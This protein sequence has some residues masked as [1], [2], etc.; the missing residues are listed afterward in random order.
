MKLDV[1]RYSDNGE[2]TLGLLFI[3]GKFSVYTLED[4]YRNKKIKHETRI[5]S[6]TYTVKLRTIGGHHER[7]KH[8]FNF[9]KGMLWL[10]DVENFEWILIHI[11]NDRKSSSGCIIVGDATNNNTTKDGFVSNS[12]SA[13]IHMYKDIIKAFDAK[14]DVTITIHNDVC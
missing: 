13:Y 3:D 12:T 1:Y 2:S 9:H 4:T 5:P 8:K 7:Y 6:G 14:E 10:Q 11:G